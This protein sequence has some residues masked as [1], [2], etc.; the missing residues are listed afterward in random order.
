MFGPRAKQ[1]FLPNAAY[2]VFSIT[3]VAEQKVHKI[4]STLNTSTA[5]DLFDWDSTL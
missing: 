1:I 2:P 4:M 5:K 3:E